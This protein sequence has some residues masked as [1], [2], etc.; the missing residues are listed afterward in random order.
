MPPD[1]ENTQD[2]EF[3]VS[4]LK[5]CLCSD[6]GCCPYGINDAVF[7]PLSVMDKRGVLKFR[8]HWTGNGLSHWHH[9]MLCNTR[10]D[11]VASD[12]KFVGKKIR[13]VNHSMRK[14]HQEV[15]RV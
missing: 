2:Y 13:I 15:S 7:E 10:M 6:L 8:V 4:N 9:T 14:E 11:V 12:P 3:P 1:M 5:P